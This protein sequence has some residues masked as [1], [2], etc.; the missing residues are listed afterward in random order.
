MTERILLFPPRPV[1]KPWGEV[2]ELPFE[3]VS[4]DAHREIAAAYQEWQSRLDKIAKLTAAYQSARETALLARQALEAEQEREVQEGVIGKAS[5]LRAKLEQLLAAADENA[6]H[7]RVRG[8]E[9]LARHAHDDFIVAIDAH[10][11][12]LLE[13]LRAEAESAADAWNE[14]QGDIQVL[15]EK[16]EKIEAPLR[17]RHRTVQE[18][19]N[20]VI[21]RTEPFERVQTEPGIPPFPSQDQFTA[22]ELFLNPPPPE[23]PVSGGLGWV[24]PPVAASW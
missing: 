2:T 21:G 11:D 23:E 5:E 13:E 20:A 1:W 16:I 24:E 22:R 14:A 19:V 9:T 17:Q 15:R 7:E 8:A 10:R 18:R 6:H 12:E 4:T 3:K